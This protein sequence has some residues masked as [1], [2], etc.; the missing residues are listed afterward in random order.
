MTDF[1]GS[2]DSLYLSMNCD[3]IIPNKYYGSVSKDDLFSSK[4]SFIK[5]DFMNKTLTKSINNVVKRFNFYLLNSFSSDKL[6]KNRK[7]H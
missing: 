5:K 2:L 7:P 4:I 6:N 3:K 1:G